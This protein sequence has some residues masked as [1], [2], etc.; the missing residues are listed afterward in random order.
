MKVFV[1]SMNKKAQ[2]TL[3]FKVFRMLG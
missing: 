1:L 2:N 3:D